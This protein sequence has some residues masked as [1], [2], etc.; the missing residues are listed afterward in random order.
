MPRYFLPVH[1][2][3][4]ILDDEGTV[5]P[6]IA[7]VRIEAIKTSGEMLRGIKGMADLWSGVDWTMTVT[8]E[9]KQRLLTLQFSGIQHV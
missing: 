2:A 8:D 6:D 9:A 1:A 3:P 7:A 5:L 4:D